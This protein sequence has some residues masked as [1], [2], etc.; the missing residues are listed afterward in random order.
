ME[1]PPE[2]KNDINSGNYVLPAMSNVCTDKCYVIC[3][4]FKQNLSKHAGVHLSQF[5][6][7]VCFVSIH[8]PQFIK[9]ELVGGDV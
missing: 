7:Q 9:V 6:A 3:T 5:Q 4:L 8:I 1:V 2:R